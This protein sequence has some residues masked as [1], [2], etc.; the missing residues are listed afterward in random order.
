MIALTLRGLTQRRLRTI[1][2]A[3]AVVLG[4]AMV[5]ASFTVSSTMKHGADSL[6]ASAYN[7]TDAVLTAQTSVNRSDIRQS[8]ASIP[9]S[10]VT[11]ARR[12]PGVGIATGEVLQ[13]VKVIG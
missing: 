12:V 7:G 9:A 6:S 1:L 5:S 3:M 8:Q 11:R 4:V 2:T 10:L 13:E